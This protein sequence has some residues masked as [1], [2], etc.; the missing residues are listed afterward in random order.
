MGKGKS[1]ENFRLSAAE[2]KM[3]EEKSDGKREIG[4][5]RELRSEMRR[6]GGDSQERAGKK[7]GGKYN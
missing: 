7:S 2:Q 6:E 4:P 5:D 1:V 3:E